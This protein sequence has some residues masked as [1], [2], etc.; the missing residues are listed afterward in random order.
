MLTI[1]H[2]FKIDLDGFLQ[3]GHEGIKYAIAFATNR[4]LLAEV[5]DLGIERLASFRFLNTKVFKANQLVAIQ[6]MLV[7]QVPDFICLYLLPAYLSNLLH[8]A[9]ELYLQ[10]T[11]QFESKLISEH[12]GDASLPRLA[13]HANY[14]LIGPT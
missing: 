7:E 9:T 11:R 2:D 13:V 8:N 6:I 14:I 4:E 10:P 5:F 1:L 3:A 12:V